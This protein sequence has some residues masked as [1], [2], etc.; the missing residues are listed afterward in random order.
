MSDIVIRN[1]EMPKSCFVDSSEHCPFYVDCKYYNKLTLKGRAKNCLF[2]ELPPHGRLV[3]L[4]RIIEN[5]KGS[6]RI[7]YITSEQELIDYLEIY[8]DLDKFAHTIILEAS[9]E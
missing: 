6:K 1:M 7:P 9:K 8:A 2:K 5:I 3:D 4:D